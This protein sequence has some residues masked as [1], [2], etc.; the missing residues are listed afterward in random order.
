LPGDVLDRVAGNEVDQ[1]ERKQRDAEKGRDDQRQAAQDEAQHG[2]R[3]VA[4]L[5]APPALPCR[6]NDARSSPSCSRAPPGAMRRTAP[7]AQPE[8][9]APRRARSPAPARRASRDRPASA[10]ARP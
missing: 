5:T 2:S 4:R 6:N 3:V 1:R 8:S 10:L 7:N 9:T